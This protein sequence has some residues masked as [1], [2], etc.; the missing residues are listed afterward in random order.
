MK[1]FILAAALT[2]ASAAQAQVIG[3]VDSAFQLVGPNHQIVVE[4]FDDPTVKGVTCYVSYAKTGGISGALGL[5]SDKSEH[6][7]ACRKTGP[8]T[9]PAGLAQGQDVFSQSRSILFKKMRVVRMIDAQ[10]NVLLYLVY[11]DKLIDGSPKN[12]ITAVAVNY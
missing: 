7:I 9:V 5:A 12:S 10:R 2:I 6:S 8:I 1:K 3:A 4:A 11:S